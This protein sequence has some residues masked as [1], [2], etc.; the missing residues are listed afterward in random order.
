MSQNILY[1]KL[2]TGEN[3]IADVD[4]NDEEFLILYQ[5]LELHVKN[6]Y[7]G[8][9]VNLSK[10]I[11]F[12]SEEEFV[13]PSKH[14]LLITTPSKDILDYYFEGIETLLRYKNE[15]KTPRDELEE[16]LAMYQRYANTNTMVH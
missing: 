5:P 15:E 6:A 2:V 10:W 3:I 4:Q 11:P 7:Q 1:L 16:L 13:L 9:S 8:A 14:I 12:T